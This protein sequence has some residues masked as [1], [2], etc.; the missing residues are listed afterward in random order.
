MKT[1]I[2]LALMLAI[3]T[4]VLFT[5]AILAIQYHAPTPM[6]VGATFLTAFSAYTTVFMPCGYYLNH[7]TEKFN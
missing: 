1:A 3:V 4:A 5:L 7:K 6:I 2:L